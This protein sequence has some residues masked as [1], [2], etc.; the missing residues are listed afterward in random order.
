MFYDTIFASDARLDRD[1]FN[2]AAREAQDIAKRLDG[3][4][5]VVWHRPAT[6]QYFASE[7]I[8]AGVNH[9]VLVYADGKRRT[10]G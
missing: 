9:Y 7:I 6:G 2:R 5:A 1:N 4:I 8:P 10:I 3:G